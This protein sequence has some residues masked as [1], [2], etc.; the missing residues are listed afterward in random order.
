MQALV[1]CSRD[2]CTYGHH[3]A[4]DRVRRLD[5]NLIPSAGSQ[6]GRIQLMV[7]NQQHMYKALHHSDVCFHES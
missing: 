4:S 6:A 3:D 7:V 1:T 2:L 5:M